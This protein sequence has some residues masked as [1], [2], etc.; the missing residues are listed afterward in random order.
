MEVFRLAKDKYASKLNASG[1]SNRWN[2]D[3]EFII[4]TG[5]SR[6]L[7]TLELLVHRNSVKLAGSY[8]MMVISIAD[9]SLITQ[10]KPSALPKNWRTIDAYSVL[11]DIGSGWY[12]S[13]KSLVLKVPSAI[14][15]KEYNYLINVNHP[16]FKKKISLIGIE[17]YFWDDRLF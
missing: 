8:K 9:E 13:N 6:S 12:K 4:Y 15:E 7:V 11:Q 14:I 17:D 3:K 10:V 1:I 16:D 2:F 5:N